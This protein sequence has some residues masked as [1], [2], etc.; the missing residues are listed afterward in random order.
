MAWS[1]SSN[2]AE[3]RAAGKEMFP[4]WKHS[5]VTYSLVLDVAADERTNVTHVATLLARRG[6]CM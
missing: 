3:S 2:R 4:S 1:L 5:G 6:A